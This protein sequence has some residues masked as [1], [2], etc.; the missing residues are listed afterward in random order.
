MDTQNK[1]Y[2]PSTCT[3]ET[4]TCLEKMGDVK[5]SRP[6]LPD[7]Q[8]LDGWKKYKNNLERAT[9][10]IYHYQETIN[11]FNPIIV[12]KNIDNIPVIDALP[13]QLII[14]DKIINIS[15]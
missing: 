7:L 15:S 12:R 10:I 9:K 8:D 6:P 14:K 5:L 3:A 1:F 11:K 2:I 13:Q 4:K